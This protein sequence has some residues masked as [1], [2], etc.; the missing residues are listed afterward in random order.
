MPKSILSDR[1]AQFVEK[2]FSHLCKMC[3]IRKINTSSFHPMGNAQVE[4][5]NG[6]ILSA[7]RCHLRMDSTESW[8]SRLNTVLYAI[9]S[10]PI[11]GVGLSSF[12]VLHGFDMRIPMD[13]HLVPFEA[14]S[15]EGSL[16]EY[17][18]GFVP[19]LRL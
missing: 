5:F 9:R 17:I 10:C 13:E 14:K 1:G 8:V 7:L 11:T 15:S 3:G 4:R 12:H 2:V 16:D 18:E 19:K 6:I